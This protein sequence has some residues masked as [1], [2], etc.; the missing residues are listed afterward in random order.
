MKKHFIRLLIVIFVIKNIKKMTCLSE[1]TVMSLVN[2]VV[3][4]IKIVI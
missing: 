4:L 2:I 3:Q 1:I